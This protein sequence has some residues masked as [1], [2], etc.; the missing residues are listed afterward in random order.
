[1]WR[2]TD[3]YILL[4]MNGLRMKNSRGWNVII[5]FIKFGFV[6]GINTTLSYLI[7]LGTLSIGC[8][9]LIANFVAFIISVFVSYVLNGK[10]VFGNRNRE[11]I[12]DWRELVRVYISYSFSSLLLNSA[13]LWVEV[14]WLGIMPQIAPII[15][16][17]ITVPLNFFLNKF[18]A[19]M[20]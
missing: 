14:H 17:L 12:F 16:L 6:G 4:R 1:M 10:F 13:L 3:R 8:H 20:K 9:Y 7:Y 5:Q 15:N 11:L 18:W 19:Y 2:V